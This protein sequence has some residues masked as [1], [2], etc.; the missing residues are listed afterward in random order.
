M[1]VLK[2]EQEIVGL[3]AR[4]EAAASYGKPHSLFA[5][6]AREVKVFML[7]KTASSS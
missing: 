2:V 1:A 5:D 7:F 6:M 3:L 4:D